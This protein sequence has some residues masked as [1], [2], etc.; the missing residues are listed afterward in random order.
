MDR[1]RF[2]NRPDPVPEPKAVPVPVEFTQ[3][4]INVT[5]LEARTARVNVTDS[6]S[7]GLVIRGGPTGL[8]YEH[9]KQLKGKTERLLIGSVDRW[10]IAEARTIANAA[11]AHITTFKVPVDEAWLQAHLVETGKI[12][13]PAPG[14]DASITSYPTFAEARE[15]YLTYIADYIVQATVDD[16]REK[17]THPKVRAALDEMRLPAITRDDVM[18]VVLDVHAKHERTAELIVA[19][20]RP[21]WTHLGEDG[22]RKRFGVTPGLMATLKAPRRK[23]VRRKVDE[24]GE[25]Q[26]WSAGYVPE[27]SELGRIIAT[28]RSGIMTPTAGAAVELT[29]WTVQRRLS[30]VTAQ[31]SDFFD[32]GELGGLWRVRVRKGERTKTRPHVIPL[33]PQVWACVERAAAAARKRDPKTRFLFPG[34][35]P[36]RAGMAVTHMNESTL[37]HLFLD[38]P[39]CGASPHDCRRTMGTHGEKLFGFARVDTG[40]IMDHEVSIKQSDR[41]TSRTKGT[42]VHDVTGAHYSLHDGTH[43]T[44]PIM[45]IWADALEKAVAEETA[46]LDLKRVARGFGDRGYRIGDPPARMLVPMGLLEGKDLEEYLERQAVVRSLVRSLCILNEDA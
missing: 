46:K 34:A 20:I 28:A 42:E 19:A 38:I 15:E 26:P 16:Y 1:G 27:I 45:Q 24:D 23:I 22:H 40:T 7:N 25:D 8:N 41:I 17:L 39:D 13:A 18:A 21:M 30:I 9:R 10:T 14:A 37:T 35:R 2:T 11:S 43:H 44:W 33:P 12:A 29:A 36:R 3:K 31:L 5:R 4:L 32:L 6:K